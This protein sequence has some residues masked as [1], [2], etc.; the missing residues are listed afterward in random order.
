M[1]SLKMEMPGMKLSSGHVFVLS[2]DVC[3]RSAPTSSA[4]ITSKEDLNKIR[5]SRHKLE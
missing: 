5:M 4:P 2:S 1:L 3:V